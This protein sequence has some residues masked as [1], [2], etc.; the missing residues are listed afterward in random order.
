ML[1]FGEFKRRLR[2]GGEPAGAVPDRSVYSGF[3]ID[4]DR[5]LPFRA[6]IPAGALTPADIAAA[7]RAGQAPVAAL[8]AALVF[9]SVDPLTRVDGRSGDL[10][11]AACRATAPDPSD[12]LHDSLAP[13]RELLWRLSGDV[14]E[15]DAVAMARRGQMLGH[16]DAR[17][18]TARRAVEDGIPVPHDDPYRDFWDARNALA[19]ARATLSPPGVLFVATAQQHFVTFDPAR[20]PELLPPALSGAFDAAIVSPTAFVIIPDDAS[21]RL[22]HFAECGAAIYHGRLFGTPLSAMHFA[23]T[24]YGVAMSAWTMDGDDA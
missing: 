13:V 14:I 19:E 15:A 1:H 24:Q 4:P 23:A 8:K 22:C 17:R 12:P 16:D 20:G 3:G 9:L 18:E 11:V 2:G 10:L 7:L 6:D 5:A 21:V